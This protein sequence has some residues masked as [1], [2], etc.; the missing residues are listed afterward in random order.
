[1]QSISDCTVQKTKCSAALAPSINSYRR[2]WGGA[3]FANSMSMTSEEMKKRTKRFAIAVIRF[4]QTLPKDSITA[5][6]TRQLV[7]SG[8]SV[9]ANY[10]SSCR[11]K[12]DADFISKMTTAEE[13]GDEALFWLEVLV[14]AEVVRTADVAWLLDEA[15]QLVRIIVVSIQTKRANMAS[16][17]SSRSNPKSNP[18]SEIRYPT[19]Q[20]SRRRL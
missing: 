6:M 15:D 1:M 16:A 12:S 10:R 5:V 4:A 20:A 18:Q 13:E 19:S 14:E 17:K 2:N 9:G 11:A 7:K 3:L 8:T